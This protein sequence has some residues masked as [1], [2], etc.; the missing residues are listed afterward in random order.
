MRRQPASIGQKKTGILNMIS[1]GASRLSPQPRCLS[2]VLALAIAAAGHCFNDRLRLPGLS[3]RGGGGGGRVGARRV[4]NEGARLKRAQPLCS[5]SLA[6]V[7]GSRFA[8]LVGCVIDSSPA[9]WPAAW[10]SIQTAAPSHPAPA[11]T[12]RTRAAAA[13]SGMRNGGEGRGRRPIPKIEIICMHI[14][15]NQHC[16]RWFGSW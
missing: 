1:S 4:L 12:C 7:R 10:A 11:L 8:T 2:L 9:P 16:V 5:F 3:S 14:K 6:A 15:L 13:A